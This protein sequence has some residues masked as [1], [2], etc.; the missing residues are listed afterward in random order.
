MNILITG[1]T[2]FVGSHMIDYILKYFI[3]PIK[4]YTVQ[5]DGWKILKMLITLMM[6]D[7][8]LLIVIYLII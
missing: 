8:D 1:G 6:I 3:K 2:G 4:R 7:L 5:K